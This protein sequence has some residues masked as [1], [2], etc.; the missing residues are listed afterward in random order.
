MYLYI[1]EKLLFTA[2]LYFGDVL[3][4]VSISINFLAALALGTWH[5]QYQCI[6]KQTS[7]EHKEKHQLGDY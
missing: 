2:G 7:D 1:T 6:T 4:K 3:Y 5:L